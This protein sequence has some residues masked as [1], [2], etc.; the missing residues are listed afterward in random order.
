MMAQHSTRQIS[1]RSRHFEQTADDGLRHEAIKQ[2]RL[3]LFCHRKT[4]R[5]WNCL[6]RAISF[7]LQPENLHRLEPL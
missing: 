1:H 4:N 6:T 5:N 7:L 2:N 3:A